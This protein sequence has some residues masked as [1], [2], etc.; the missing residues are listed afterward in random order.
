MPRENLNPFKIAQSQFQR[1]AETLNLDPG[2]RKIL[3]QP[4]RELSV[5]IPVRMDDGR[6]EV[7]RGYRVQ[8]NIARG[9]AKG[10]IRY[11]PDVT[12]DEVRA[13]A[14]WMT[15]KCACL[16]LPYGGGK[17]GV[18]VD[19]R[20]L[21]IGELE[22]LTRRYASEILPVIGPEQDIPAPDVYTN[23][24]T[25]AWIMDTY[26][27]TKGS[28][29]LGV[30]TGKP[31]SLGG[32]KG[33]DRATARG[34]QFVLREACKDRK[35]KLAGATVAIQGFGNA[36]GTLATLL[37]DDGAKIV[38]AS[39]STAG[40]YD[41]K[42]LDPKALHAHKDAGKPFKTFKGPKQITNKALLEL[43]VDILCPS[44]LE[45]QI[46]GANVARVKAKIIAEAAN[47][48]TTPLADENLFKRGRTVIPDILANAGGVTVSYFEW[49]QDFSSFF[50]EEDEVDKRL[51]RAMVKAYRHVAETA[52]KHKCSLRD[53]A[54]IVAV[55]RVAEATSLRGLF[56]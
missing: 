6:I 43:N 50:W 41:P 18:V 15:W 49:V 54:Y 30:V 52:K 17:G 37:H 29:A 45:N 19:P 42:G 40:L 46:T 33:R 8:H 28:T 1:A 22:R 13:L 56:P 9:P 20:K 53:A 23:S 10:G 39:D 21:S 12:R 34:V 14:S 7:F 3:S 2:M 36:G 27:M 35:L 26:S 48:P 4:K 44:A 47:G 32:S 24:Q 31:V 55:G 25:M 11:H 16:E 38:A 51:E 5:S